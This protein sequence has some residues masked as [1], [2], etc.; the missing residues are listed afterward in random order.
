[1]RSFSKNFLLLLIVPFILTCTNNPVGVVQY[2]WYP[3][4]VG[5]SWEYTR[6]YAFV[7]L[8]SDTTCPLPF[9]D[10]LF[11][12]VRV[13]ISKMDT[14]LD[15]IPVYELSKTIQDSFT[16]YTGLAY[17][18]NLEDGLYF[19]AYYNS[20]NLPP[21]HNSTGK[22]LSFKGKYFS[23]INEILEWL[24]RMSFSTSLTSD[25]LIYYLP[26]R[27]SIQYPLQTGNQWTYGIVGGHIRFDKKI[28]SYELVTV[29]A[30]SFSCYKIQWL[31][32]LND[33]GKW[34]SDIEFFDY[35][36]SIG[37]VKRSTLLKDLRITDY[38]FGHYATFDVFEEIRLTRYISSVSALPK[39]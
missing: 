35:I 21:L 28:I 37:I 11:S 27:K 18:N 19:Y 36:S 23:S 5:N 25:S 13:Q 39:E 33:D 9:P 31:F 6:F 22:S 8:Q 14:L 30:G 1:M 29:P 24:E 17:Y 34:E 3:L 15:S 26:P 16:S 32:D 38:C 20:I 7:N 12:T 10:T 4:A 2:D